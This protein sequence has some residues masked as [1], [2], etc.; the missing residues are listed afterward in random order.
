MKE[1][2]KKKQS[3]EVEIPIEEIPKLPECYNEYS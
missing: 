3:W 1:E 2:K